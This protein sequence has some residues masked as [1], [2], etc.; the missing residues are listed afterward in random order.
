MDIT[1]TEINPYKET[2]IKKA[3]EAKTFEEL[4]EVCSVTEYVDRVQMAAIVEG[5]LPDAPKNVTEQEVIQMKEEE[6]DL[7]DDPKEVLRQMYEEF[8]KEEGEDN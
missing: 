8:K 1:F 5:N 4:D 7:A 6:Q 2:L 3:D